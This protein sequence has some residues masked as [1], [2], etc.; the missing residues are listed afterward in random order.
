MERIGLAEKFA[1]FDER[2]RTKLVAELN[3]QEV[4]LVKAQ[5]VFPW[6]VH[7]TI[8]ELFLV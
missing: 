8:D 4:K 6:H 5:G 7:E 3:G 1:R 2:W